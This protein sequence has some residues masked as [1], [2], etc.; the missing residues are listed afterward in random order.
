MAR[1]TPRRP[2]VVTVLVAVLA[3]LGVTALGGGVEMVLLRN[4]NDYLPITVIEG[5]AIVETFLLPG[6]VLGGVFGLGSLVAAI[7]VGRRPPV[8]SLSNVERW[9]GRH[10]SWALTVLLGIGFATWMLLEWVWLGTP[11]AGD[12]TASERATTW[13]LYG[14]YDAVAIALLVLP[15]LAGVRQHLARRKS[16]DPAGPSGWARTTVGLGAGSVRRH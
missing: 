2:V 4:G 7:G 13:A 16:H 3:F 8:T 10:W 9:T 14:I 11:W 12:A 6:L 5:V 1:S 15:H